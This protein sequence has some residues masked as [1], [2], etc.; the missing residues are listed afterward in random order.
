MPVGATT[1]SSRDN[2]ALRDKLLGR[3]ESRHDALDNE[4]RGDT[5]GRARAY[6]RVHL[7]LGLGRA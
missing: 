7:F 5:S 3:F 2:A 4:F 6:I 1:D